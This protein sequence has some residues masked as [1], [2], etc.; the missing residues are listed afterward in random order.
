MTTFDIKVVANN[1]FGC[2][3][4]WILTHQHCTTCLPHAKSRFLIIFTIPICS[5][6]GVHLMGMVR[7]ENSDYS[8]N[9]VKNTEK[10]KNFK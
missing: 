6:R 9:D 2:Q 7:A 5:N 10:D 4:K 3:Q 8:K 1:D